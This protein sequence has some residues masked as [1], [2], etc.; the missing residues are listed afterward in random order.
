[1]RV[2]PADN[3]LV[4]RALNDFRVEEGGRR[5]IVRMRGEGRFRSS[6]FPEFNETGRR[7]LL[8]L[9][10][11]AEWKRPGFLWRW[12]TALRLPYLLFSA[13]PLLLVACRRYAET[14]ALPWA[15][16]ALL[17]LSVVLVHMSCNLWSDYEDHLRGVDT[18]E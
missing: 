6:V 14:G 18:P 12:L 8:E 3:P 17:F 16:G 11:E 9:I 1:H 10:P 2:L 4:R 7:V 15:E 13:L 5:W